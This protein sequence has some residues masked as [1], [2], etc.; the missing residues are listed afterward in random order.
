M[1]DAAGSNATA[2]F[3][4]TITAAQGVL[5]LTTASLPNGT[6]GVPYSA[7][8][9]V[10]GGTAPYSCV[11]TAGTLP[12][13][14]T[15]TG[16]VVSGTPTVAGT[17]GLT[18]K[19]TD[20]GAPA[21][22]VAGPESITISPA[23]LAI[24]TGTLPGG[25]VG[26]VYSSTLGVAGG[27]GPYTCSV[28]SGS[29]PAGLA[30]GA[31]CLVTGTPTVAGTSTP[32][33]KVT[34]S[35]NP[36]LT[37]TGPVSITI[38]PAPLS[39]TTGTL[40]NGTVGVVYSSTLGITGGTGPYTCS[41]AS[42]SLPA[43]LAFG[44]NCLVTGTPTVAGTSTP[45]V[46]VTDSSNPILTTSGPVSITIVAAP[47]LTI[48]SPPAGT[49]G[50]PYTGVVGVTGGKG[51]YTCKLVSGTIPAGL[52]LNNCTVTGTPITAGSSPI[53][54]AASDSSSPA[55]TTNGPATI[56]IN[57]APLAITTGTLPNGT[58]ACGV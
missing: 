33:V 13:G 47:V 56:V 43:G 22:T 40:P 48:S 42:G 8:I 24:T 34:D 52:T 19:A 36:T 32:M 25:T 51:P 31:N 54:I 30:F 15:L 10:M 50:T 28:A 16:C 55:V 23:P 21:A 2:V 57:P 18:V 41:V 58:V 12:A 6:V 38:A 26:V 29:L 7:T 11:F 44:A 14:L 3:G 27:T 4:I 35:S 45:V 39:I 17:S 53:V 9:G 5:T 49:V 46:K 20:S 37:V 1:Q